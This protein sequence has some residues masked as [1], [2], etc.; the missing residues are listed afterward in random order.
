M[1]FRLRELSEEGLG[2]VAF[3]FISVIFSVMTHYALNSVF[4]T[5][6]IYILLRNFLLVPIIISI[7]LFKLTMLDL[8]TWISYIKT[9]EITLFVD[10]FD[11]RLGHSTRQGRLADE[12]LGLRDSQTW[13]DSWP[14]LF[15]LQDSQQIFYSM[16]LF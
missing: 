6:C 2:K 13:G 14:N 5:K 15:Y 9:F 3:P 4:S 12:K 16:S 11:T 10:Y 7:I 1:W 8:V